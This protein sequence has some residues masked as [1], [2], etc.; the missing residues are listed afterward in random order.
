MVLDLSQ[1]SNETFLSSVDN[2]SFMRF[3]QGG[4]SEDFRMKNGGTTLNITLS[5]GFGTT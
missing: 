5:S 3:G 1:E 2:S 4:T